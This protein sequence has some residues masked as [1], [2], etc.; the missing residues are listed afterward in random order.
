[1]AAMIAYR[2]SGDS[3]AGVIAA[4]ITSINPSLF[5]FS[6]APIPMTLAGVLL[7]CAIAL[8]FIDDFR[9]SYRY[10]GLFALLVWTA[11]V[12][13]KI[14]IFLLT[15]IGGIYMI[16]S[17]IAQ[18]RQQEQSLNLGVFIFLFGF[19]ILIVQ[20]LYFTSFFGRALENIFVSVQVDR[21]ELTETAIEVGG[22][23]RYATSLE[24]SIF[25]L[26]PLLL[27]LLI[28]AFAG[29]ELFRRRGD[30]N[31]RLL[32]TSAV[33]L[34]GVSIPGLFIGAAPGFKRVFVYLAPIVAALIG[35]SAVRL[36]SSSL[37]GRKLLVGIVL[38]SLL[39]ISPVTTVGNFDH[40]D[41]HRQYLT[42][43][44][45]AEKQFS[46]Q[47]A[48]ETVFRSYYYQAEKID[49]ERGAQGIKG[50]QK[51]VNNF[52]LQEYGYV[53]I[54]FFNSSLV[55]KD[56]AYVALR[57]DVSLYR[58]PGGRYRLRWN[59]ENGLNNTR[60]RIYDNGGSTLFYQRNVSDAPA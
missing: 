41:A 29:L 18:W 60:A 51:G 6:V 52:R 10:V 25:H 4:A 22:V 21:A 35:V 16:Y 19:C 55:A 53:A 32:Q 37:P 42:E 8:L 1:M 14:P 20:W 17:G 3:N 12:V 39:G 24:V 23:S 48:T 28:G 56:Y 50:E 27:T 43:Q 13:H 54:E 30:R 31:V 33:V 7:T 44:E 49:L 45:V 2:V 5:K 11:A 9:S 40:P 36:R 46:N 26:S 15:A 34:A 58:L 59:P 57:D 38:I 47:H